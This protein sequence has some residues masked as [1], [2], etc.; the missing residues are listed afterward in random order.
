ME[1]GNKTLLILGIGAVAL[2][3]ILNNKANAQTLPNVLPPNPDPIPLPPAPPEL[4]VCKGGFKNE[5]GD[6]LFP[7]VFTFNEDYEAKYTPMY[8]P[9]EKKSVFFKKGTQISGYYS[10]EVFP[11][12]PFEKMANNVITNLDGTSPQIGMVGVSW[13]NIPAYLLTEGFY[14]Y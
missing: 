9:F 14:E 13:L 7:K 1:S 8:P 2:Y 10:I 4:D 11:P 12:K 5:I 6:C 3:L